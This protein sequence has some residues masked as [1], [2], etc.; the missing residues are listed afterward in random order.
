[1]RYFDLHKSTC[2]TI[3]MHDS[4]PA[5]RRA[6]SKHACKLSSTSEIRDAL[7]LRLSNHTPVIMVKI[8]G[9]YS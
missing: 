3:N 9:G 2:S 6:I 4:T 5:I 8:L 7:R 1:M